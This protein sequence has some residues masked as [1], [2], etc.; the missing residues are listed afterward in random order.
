M[1]TAHAET[2]YS[3][4]NYFV[5]SA[6]HAQTIAESVISTWDLDDSV[7]YGLPEV[8]DRYHVWRVPILISGTHKR[9]GELVVDA[10][11]GVVDSKKSTTITSVSSRLSRINGSYLKQVHSKQQ[12]L[13][14][15]KVP[16]L[17]N[18]IISG[19]SEESLSA[20]PSE[21][22]QL[23]FTSPP[24]F[25][26][27]PDYADYLSYD[28]YLCSL[29][30]VINQVHRVLEDGRF[31]V[32]NCSP[33]LVRRAKRSEASKR[34]A[35]P[36]DIHQIFIKEGFEFIDDIIWEKPEGAGWATGRG[37]RFAADRNPL[38]YKA[39][40]VTEYVLVYRKKSDKLI[41][42]HIRNHHNQNL[43]KKSKIKNG[44]EKTN[45]WKI[46]P[47]HCKEHPAIF[48]TELAEKVIQYYSFIGDAV[49]DPYAGIGTV[50]CAAT[51]LN[52]RFVLSEVNPNYI[53]YIRHN[54]VSWLGKDAENVHCVNCTSAPTE[55]TLFEE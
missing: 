1:R 40:P 6:G 36:F 31:A 17:R 48:P 10:K 13:N 45:I 25:N 22:I 14:R 54:L 29:S 9:I 50:G 8:D 28:E 20:L 4:R 18:T 49:L 19:N 7:S 26:A 5:Q 46:K 16:E 34:I 43:V 11:L 24:Y 33:V 12:S 39:V 2:V 38:Q 53:D 52:R 30:K 51:K 27:R 21:S 35:V 37:R 42:W 32:I 3:R 15:I 23:M 41:D 44:Y 47:A 55:Y